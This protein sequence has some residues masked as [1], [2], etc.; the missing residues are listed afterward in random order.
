[1]D[2]AQLIAMSKAPRVTTNTRLRTIAKCTAYNCVSYPNF[3]DNEQE[4]TDAILGECIENNLLNEL[5]N[6]YGG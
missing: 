3:R 5:L 1:M 4:L 2:K 6:I